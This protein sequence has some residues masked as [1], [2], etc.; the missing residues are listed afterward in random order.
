MLWVWGLL[1]VVIVLLAIMLKWLG[2][3]EK[4][5][6]FVSERIETRTE[7]REAQTALEA[8][9]LNQ[10]DKLQQEVQDAAKF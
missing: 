6:K 9:D 8:T 3:T 2:K 1:A 4:F 5:E 7:L 10:L